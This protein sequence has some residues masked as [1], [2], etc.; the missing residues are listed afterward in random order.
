MF[1]RVL[2]DNPQKGPTVPPLSLGAIVKQ[3][4]MAP[5]LCYLT[6]SSKSR[7]WFR[8]KSTQEARDQVI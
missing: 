3:E 2:G 8:R 1:C 7:S 4:S 6:H 5:P